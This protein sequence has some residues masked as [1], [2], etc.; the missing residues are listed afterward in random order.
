MNLQL[1]TKTQLYNNI[2]KIV[3]GDKPKDDRKSATKIE[4]QSKEKEA[5]RLA[6]EKAKRIQIQKDMKDK[7]AKD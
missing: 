3:K 7:E 6:L 1:K 5:K 4:K 2:D